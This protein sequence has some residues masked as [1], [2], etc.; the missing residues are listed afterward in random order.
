MAQ[1]LCPIL[2]CSAT[3]VFYSYSHTRLPRGFSGVAF[4]AVTYLLLNYS[5]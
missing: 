2:L 4:Y 1:N 3:S 5:Y